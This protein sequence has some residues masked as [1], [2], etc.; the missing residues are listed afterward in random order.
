MRVAWRAGL[1][2][3]GGMEGGFVVWVKA[4]AG[5]EIDLAQG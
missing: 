4:R 3:E 5:V 1:W 2:V